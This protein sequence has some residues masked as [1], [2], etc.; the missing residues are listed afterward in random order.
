MRNGRI[1]NNHGALTTKDKKRLGNIPKRWRY[2]GTR[3]FMLFREGNC[4]YLIIE[5]AM[6]REPVGS[7]RIGVLEDSTEFILRDE[8]RSE[9]LAA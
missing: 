5:R 3:L 7:F 2:D 4:S 1:G 8:N 6:L 9:T